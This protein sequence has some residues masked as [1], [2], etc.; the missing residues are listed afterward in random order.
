MEI[1]LTTWLQTAH[2]LFFI[3]LL[4]LLSHLGGKLAN[5]FKAPRVTGYL[6]AGMLFSPSALGLFHETLIN[7]ELSLITDI[8]LSVIAFSIGGSLS[9]AKVK[10]LGKQILWIT[11]AEASG[12]F[13]AVAVLLSLVFFLLYGFQSAA[14]AY[15][16]VYLPM[17]LLIGALSAATAP[18]A[19]L[20][21]IHEYRA[22]GP[23]TSV[24][25][26]VVALDDALAI[27]FFAF[28]VAGAKS[29][30]SQEPV[31]WLSALSLPLLAI[32]MSLLIG[33]FSGLL[34]RWLIRFVPR[35]K[36]MLGVMIGAVF[37]VG[38]LAL[39]LKV[40]PLLTNMML[41]FVVANF[42]DRH[43]DLFATVEGIEEP[44]FGMF[45]TLAGAHLDLRVIG[46]A[47]G[48]ALLI[49]LARFAGK[50]SGSYLGAVLTRAPLVV[51]KYLCF[52]ILPQAGVAVG[53]VLNAKDLFAFNGQ[54]GL[55]VNAVLGAVIINELLSPFFVRYALLKATETNPAD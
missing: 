24:L 18:A 31:T 12:A 40:S 38:G 15:L 53:L 4:L 49:T 55:M 39:S 1:N 47:G 13:L 30:A 52:A 45:F 17:A 14:P 6:L 50:L 36:A 19:T 41:G 37:L 9:L 48:I 22:Q 42:V 5:H 26:G 3:G 28:A 43:E 33:G 23:L 20:A 32:L 51:R 46:A 8:A 25:L 7:D 16:N 11:L 29:L 54:S 35:N 2:P 44:V 10:R 27:F 21:I 34:L